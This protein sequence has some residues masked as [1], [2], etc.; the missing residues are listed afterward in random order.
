MPRQG[1]IFADRETPLSAGLLLGSRDA[2]GCTVRDLIYRQLAQLLVQSRGSYALEIARKRAVAGLGGPMSDHLGRKPLML[3][4]MIIVC[5]GAVATALA[6]GPGM[7]FIG[8]LLVGVGIGIDFPVSSSYISEVL[9]KR[10]R[11][12][13]MAMTSA[14][15]VVLVNSS[16]SPKYSPGPSRRMIA[17]RP[18]RTS[19]SPSAS[20]G[21]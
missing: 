15:R 3:S 16:T 19:T 2:A 12:R 6:K 13:L 5:V 7:L 1:E 10:S 11:A 4:D 14:V 18:S 20:P 9:P 8:Q 17:P 21:C